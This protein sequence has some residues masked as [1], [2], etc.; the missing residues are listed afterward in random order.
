MNYVTIKWNN[1]ASNPQHCIIAHLD[2]EPDATTTIDMYVSLLFCR[3]NSE[4]RVAT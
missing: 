1:R 2:D 4:H 3:V